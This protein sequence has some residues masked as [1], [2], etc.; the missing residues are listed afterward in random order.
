MSG[1]ERFVKPTGGIEVK[2]QLQIELRIVPELESYLRPHTAE[3]SA[4]LE[5]AMRKNGLQSPI[6]YWRDGIIID[7]HNRY[8][9]CKKLGI[10]LRYIEVPQELNTIEEVKLWMDENQLEGK[11]RI[12]TPEERRERRASILKRKLALGKDVQE[13][14]M[15]VA[16]ATGLTPRTIYRDLEIDRAVTSLPEKVKVLA[17]GEKELRRMS[18]PA[19]KALAEL[20]EAAQ[21]DILERNDGNIRA[22]ERELS[23]RRPPKEKR[24]KQKDMIGEP[25]P[26]RVTPT[27]E[28]KERAEKR[29]AVKAIREALEHLARANKAMCEAKDAVTPSEFASWR[30]RMIDL[31]KMWCDFI[32]EQNRREGTE[33]KEE[34]SDDNPW[35]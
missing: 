24:P 21:E 13:A 27:K 23:K 19:V 11:G 5:Q 18:R 7:G 4:D 6:V 12:D 20:G 33:L 10:P 22:V 34:S 32:E 8:H 28:D 26:D 30:Q 17:G 35:F 14:V 31:D 29:P 9:L 16:E 1:T 25:R 15:E 2:E 3:E